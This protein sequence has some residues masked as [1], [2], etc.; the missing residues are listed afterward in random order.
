[1]LS[2]GNRSSTLARMASLL[3]R[4]EDEAHSAFSIRMLTFRSP[5]PVMIG[6]NRCLQ[7]SIACLFK[8]VQYTDDDIDSTPTREALRDQLHKTVDIA[9]KRSLSQ[10]NLA[11]LAR[12]VL[13]DP[14]QAS[15]YDDQRFEPSPPAFSAGYVRQKL[16]L[17]P[18]EFSQADSQ[19]FYSSWQDP[20]Q[21]HHTQFGTARKT[22]ALN[23]GSVPDVVSLPTF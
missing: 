8:S 11:N 5:I 16:T 14:M 23:L 15:S 19:K 17:N 20:Q 13:H 10:A 3:N 22:S 1:M 9:T 18:Q 12:T 2:A 6:V 21:H 7:V 4:F